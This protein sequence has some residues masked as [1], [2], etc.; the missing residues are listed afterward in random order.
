MRLVKLHNRSVEPTALE[1]AC[2]N[3]AVPRGN[4][5]IGIN[6]TFLMTI[7][8]STISGGVEDSISFLRRIVPDDLLGDGMVGF[9]QFATRTKYKKTYLNSEWDS[10]LVNT[11]DLSK[12]MFA[13]E[14]TAIIVGAIL[15]YL[16]KS[17][18]GRLFGAGMTF[19][20]AE[21]TREF[22]QAVLSELS[23]IKEITDID[24][25]AGATG[26]T[27]LNAQ[28]WELL[29]RGLDENRDRYLKEGILL[30]DPPLPPVE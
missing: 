27:E 7:V 6:W 25:A 24:F 22:R 13:K 8:A 18:G 1:L 2:L 12:R 19:R 5:D 11:G 30:L 14:G 26:G 4:D 16:L 29:F 28:F 9:G 17:F 21:N 20:T 23:E 15:A 3:G 10:R